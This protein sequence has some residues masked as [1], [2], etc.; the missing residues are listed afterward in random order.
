MKINKNR[1]TSP[2]TIENTN[3]SQLQNSRLQQL[4]DASITSTS[5]SQQSLNNLAEDDDFHSSWAEDDD[6]VDIPQ[7]EI[8]QIISAVDQQTSKLQRELL[9]HHYRL[10]HLPFP[11]LQ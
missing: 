10:K 1:S 5:A 4:D 9:S 8:K 3:E 7:T 11:Y 2:R 6:F